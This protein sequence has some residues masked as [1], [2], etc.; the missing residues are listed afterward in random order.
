MESSSFQPILFIKS[1]H[2]NS[3]RKLDVDSSS[4]DKTIFKTHAELQ[5]LTP[6]QIKAQYETQIPHKR[7]YDLYAVVFASRT[8]VTTAQGYLLC[9]YKKIFFKICSFLKH[10]ELLHGM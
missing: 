3:C 8:A 6:A 5:S 9:V 1:Q 10:S 4:G 7:S 2:G